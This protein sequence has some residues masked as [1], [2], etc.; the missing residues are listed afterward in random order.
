MVAT[1]PEIETAAIAEEIAHLTAAFD[2]AGPTAAQLAVATLEAH[3][4]EVVF[5]VPGVHTLA[6]Y[7]ALHHSSIRHVL[8]RHEQGAGF[9]AD[10]YARASGRPGVAVI[11]TGP[12]ITNVAT[13]IGEAYS[14]SS[15]VFV[16]SS[17]VERAYVDNMRGSLHD[18]KDQ[19]GVMASVTQWNTRVNHAGDAAATVAEAFRRL[20]TG[21]PLPVH[22]EIPIDV[23]D[24]PVPGG[25]PVVGRGPGPV[26][27]KPDLL[28]EAANRLKASQRPAIY[29]GGGAVTSPA[30][31]HILHIAERLGAPVLTSI[32][33]KG[34]V[35]EDHPH[36]LGGLWS[37]GN[38]VDDLL[39]EVDCLLVIG[40]KLGVQ[41]TW[42]FKLPL[43]AELI[44]IDVDPRELTLNARP[45]LPIL[46]DAALAAE[47]IEA[48]LS[49][50]D[51]H[52]PG[53]GAE[54]IGAVREAARRSAW[55]LDRRPYLDALRRAVP[56]D[57]V[58][59][60]DMTMMSYVACGLYPAYLPRTF[61]FPSGYGTLGFALPAALGA[62]VA[63]PEAAVVC[64][65]GDGGFQYTMEEVGAAIH[66]RIGVPIVI[67]NDS[68][69]S[70]VKDAQ[71]RTREGRY[72]AVDLVNP[73]YVK[74]ADAYG[75][76]GVRAESPEAMER[77]ITDAL[78]RDVPTIID[79][80]I[81][82][83]V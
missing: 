82:P 1:N 64:V 14:D 29:C 13:P 36:V 65:V 38:P 59:A 54:R 40:S 5:G 24:E 18:L 48:I 11:I 79:V 57:G 61:L 73:D 66:H 75:I 27:P 80:P 4:V 20:E 52:A 30:P 19:L 55:G 6:L 83:W 31:D 56:R 67:F 62:K 28:I 41:A 39:R 34:S 3:G 81:A 16:L 32:M 50:E 70:A 2:A 45:S 22:V 42:D 35:P 46:G 78:T 74:L 77:A 53:F 17:N 25:R 21:R 10:G 69:Y 49:G 9:M 71:G 60:F 58:V 47:G 15:P 12:G 51:F 23:L 44:R 8:A 68:T 63:R 26:R 43:P 33:G 37:I 7:D 72:I 76:P